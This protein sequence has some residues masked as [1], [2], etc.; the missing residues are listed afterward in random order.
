MRTIATFFLI[1]STQLYNRGVSIPCVLELAYMTPDFS[2]T[3]L[4]VLLDGLKQRHLLQSALLFL[5]AHRPLAFMAGQGL[6]LL[7]PLSE[8]VGVQSASV[9]GEI[10]CDREVLKQWEERLSNLSSRRETIGKE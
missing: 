8:L 9:W 6:H 1:S 7:A 3:H 4:E 10:L 2:V 5:V